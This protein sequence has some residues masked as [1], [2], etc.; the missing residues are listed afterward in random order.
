[1]NHAA[2]RLAVLL[3]IVFGTLVAALLMEPI[4]QNTSYHDFADRRAFFGLPHFFDVVSNLPF[5]LVGIAGLRFCASARMIGSRIEWAVFFAGV[6][7]VAFGSAYYHWAPVNAT[8]VWDR[9]PMTLAFMGLLAAL[10]GESLGARAGLFVLGPAVFVGGASIVHWHLT[11]DLRLYGW[12]QFFPVLLIPLLLVLFPARFTHRA[13]LLVGFGFYGLAKVAEVTDRALFSATGGN[14]SGH[15]LKHL[16][17]AVACFAL[18]HM[19][20]KRSAL[21]ATSGSPRN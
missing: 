19:L 6:A 5:L 1:M 11:D 9:V 17:A 15:T 7:L 3:L 18:L 20:R 12:V 21:T 14:F 10:I 16:L 4:P 2:I 8:L 13:L